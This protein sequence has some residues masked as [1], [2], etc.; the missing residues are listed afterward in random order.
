MLTFATSARANSDTI[1]M[2]GDVATTGFLTVE[3]GSLYYETR[4]KGDVII[5]IHGGLVDSRIWDDQMESFAK[6]HRVVRYDL[7][8]FGKSSAPAAKF[9]H[10]TDLYSL[11][12]TLGITRANVIG[13][14][15]GG[16]IAMDFTLEHPEMVESL[17]LVD[18]A[19]RG[20]VRP[21]DDRLQS[22]YRSSRSDGPQKFAE[23][24]LSTPMFAGV[25]PEGLLRARMLQMLA[26]NAKALTTFSLW[27]QPGYKTI[28]RLPDIK[29]PT[30][31]VAGSSDHP[32]LL[33]IADILHSR[34]PGSRKV[35]IP[36]ASH[37][38]NAE[39]AEEFNSVTLRFLRESRSHR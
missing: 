2:R 10:V 25:P 17:S 4:G 24:M 15:L 29:V 34:I 27:L 22:I 3:G 14:S 11:C 5:L 7:R 30:L 38:P 18:S 39:H 8:G 32:D 33:A 1:T 9:S 26:E 36:G 31:I 6:T 13:V 21:P 28:D 19:L 23:K 20:D 12:R 35:I 37:H 16:S